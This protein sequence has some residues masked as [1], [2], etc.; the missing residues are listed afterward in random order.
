MNNRE[1][2]KK[3]VVMA[4][5]SALAFFA[6]ALLRI[7]ML[8]A[9]PLVLSYE[10]KDVIIAI[11][12][13]LFGPLPAAIIA[14]VVAFIEMVTVSS[15][16]PIGF[17]MNVI[18]SG[19]FVCSSAI[20]YKRHRTI[21]GAITGLSVACLTTTIVMLLYNY[22][23][24][25]IFMGVP[26]AVVASLLVPLFLPFNIIKSIINAA[27]IMMIYKPVVTALRK[28]NL[29]IESEDSAASGKFNIGVFLL[30]CFVLA[31]AIVLVLVL[32]G[33]M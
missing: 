10:P 5:L 3:M 32:Q 7:P 17:I 25:P 33:Q 2:L 27:I 9:G 29:L 13:L 24:T 8:W 4:L 6:V 18:S 22:F 23:F 16:G 31:T 12:G 14:I 30:S 28:S 20:I 1:S 11:G 26:R 21:K 19:C 15:T